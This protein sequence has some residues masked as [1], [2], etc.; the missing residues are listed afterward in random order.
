MN[1][2]EDTI[3]CEH[4]GS[5]DHYWTDC[6]ECGAKRKNDVEILNEKI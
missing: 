3:W 2:Y 6:P 1:Y 4:C 5:Y